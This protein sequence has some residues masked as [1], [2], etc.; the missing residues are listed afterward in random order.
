MFAAMRTV[1]YAALFVGFLLIYLPVRVLA[2]A[3]IHR[4]AGFAAPQTVGALI[5]LVGAALAMWCVVSFVRIGKGTPAPFDA[6]RHLVVRGPYRFVRNPMYIGAALALAGAALFYGSIWLLAYA[7]G[8]LL[9]S[10]FFVVLYE[11]PTLKRNFGSEYDDYRHRVHR[12]W[13]AL[14]AVPRG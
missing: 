3:G 13:P 10:H 4:P 6:P 9:V 2:R 12:W 8:F 14:R 11:E 7:A 1:V 5:T